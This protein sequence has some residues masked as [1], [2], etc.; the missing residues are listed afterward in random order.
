[1]KSAARVHRNHGAPAAGGGQGAGITLYMQPVQDLTIEAAS[2]ARNTS[3]RCRPDAAMHWRNGCPGCDRLR[4]Q[5]AAAAD[6]ASDLQDQGLRPM[7]TS[8]ATPPRGW[9]SPRPSI[10]S[11]LY[12]AFGQR[13]IS[14]IF[15]QANQYRVVL[16]ANP[17][18]CRA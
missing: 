15:T 3:S 9:A 5:E 4:G 7:S 2:A 14:T 12:D 16:E 13:L 6:V 10:D 8:T 11:A 18:R 17:N 1:M